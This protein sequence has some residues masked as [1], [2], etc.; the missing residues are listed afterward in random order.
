MP[1]DHVVYAT[2]DLRATVELL[3][4]RLGVAPSPGGRH[5][6]QGTRNYL[7][8]L[9]PVSYLEII[10]PDPDQPPPAGPRPFGLD[11][12]EAPLLAGWSIRT[13]QIEERVGRARARGYDP[14]QV[15]SMTRTLP[16]GGVLEWTLAVREMRAFPS[17]IPFLID[18]GD[19]PH[20]SATAAQGVELLAFRGETPGLEEARRILDALEVDLKLDPGTKT[21]LIAH[22]RGPRGE[23]VL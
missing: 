6:G 13:P 14:G 5:T 17:V 4:E 22:L 3:T 1:L 15:R 18:W 9:G 23:I 12:L 8:S 20:P 21:K 16:S 7:L 10:G 11:D 19:T 2:P